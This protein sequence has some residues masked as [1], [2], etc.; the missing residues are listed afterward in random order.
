MTVQPPLIP[1][2]TDATAPEYDAPPPGDRG[3]LRPNQML[4]QRPASRVVS[5]PNER[6]TV[7]VFPDYDAPAPASPAR[8]R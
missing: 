4:V 5:I 1:L 6:T 7:V 8:G 3:F 2:P